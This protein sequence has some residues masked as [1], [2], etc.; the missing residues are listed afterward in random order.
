MI[1]LGMEK[2]DSGKVTSPKITPKTVVTRIPAR[3]DPLIFFTS[4]IPIIRIPASP[5]S[6]DG[7]RAPK[8]T[9]VSLLL[10]IIS[11]FFNPIKVIKRPIPAGIAIRI[12]SGIALT[13]F[14]RTP[15]I[16]RTK[17]RTPEIKTTPSAVSQLILLPMTS[18]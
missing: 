12:E 7:V 1:E 15:I 3:I 13:I 11:R 8:V 14:S 2:S 17:K 4:R 5:K 9:S 6:T 10:T 16:V 18:E